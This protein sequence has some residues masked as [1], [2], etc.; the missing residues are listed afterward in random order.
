MAGV[1]RPRRYYG[2][3]GLLSTVGDY[4]RFHQMMLNGGELDGVRIF[5]PRTVLRAVSE[6]SYLELD[7]SLATVRNHIHN[8]LEKLDVHS[9]LEAVSLAF[10]QG[11]VGQSAG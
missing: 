5:E 4:H 1:T 11:W 2:G 6:Q 10:R 7:L 3:G 9:K 8:I